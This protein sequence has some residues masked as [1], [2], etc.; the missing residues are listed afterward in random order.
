MIAT[1]YVIHQD[2]EPLSER[3]RVGAFLG[4]A[5]VMAK[6][7][8]WGISREEALCRVESLTDREIA[9]IANKVDQIPEIAGGYEL[10]GSLLSIIGLAIYTIFM[11]L[12]VY[13]SRTMETEEKPEIKKTQ[14]AALAK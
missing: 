14:E 3:A 4:R 8:S 12:A 2:S 1:E 10:D 7:Q 11:I 9:F 5:D 13:F 6:L